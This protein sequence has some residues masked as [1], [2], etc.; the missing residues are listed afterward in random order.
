MDVKYQG[1][2]NEW[3]KKANGKVTA[4]FK[5]DFHC[6]GCAK[7]VKKAARSLGGFEEVKLDCAANKLTVTGKEDPTVMKEMLE[8]KTKKIVQLVSSQPR[9]DDCGDEKPEEKSET[10]EEYEKPKE[11]KV[12]LKIR[13]HCEY[14]CVNELKKIVG[15]FKGVEKVDVAAGKDLVTVKGTMVVKELAAYLKEKLRRSVEIVEPKNH[16][17]GDERANISDGDEKKKDGRFCVTEVVALL[18]LM[19]KKRLLYY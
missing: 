5:M 1:G 13:L 17:G 12:V 9:E 16:E 6:E 7:K 10:E 19:Q 18:V 2:K 4:V 14:G 15:K 8:K 3:E 11:S